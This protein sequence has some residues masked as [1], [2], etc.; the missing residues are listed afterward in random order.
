LLWLEAHPEAPD[1]WRIDVIAILLDH[2][3]NLRE[4]KH[5]VNTI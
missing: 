2:Q 3:D 5:F 4:L 1:D